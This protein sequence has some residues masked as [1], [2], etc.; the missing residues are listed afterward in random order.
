MYKIYNF[1]NKFQQTKVTVSN[2]VHTHIFTS[3]K[4][5]RGTCR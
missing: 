1:L 2:N 3:D 4:R 5:K